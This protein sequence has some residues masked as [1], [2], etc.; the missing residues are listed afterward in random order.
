[1]PERNLIKEIQ[2]DD[3][4]GDLFWLAVSALAFAYFVYMTSPYGTAL[5]VPLNM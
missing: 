3:I 5:S 4:F 1:M 2:M